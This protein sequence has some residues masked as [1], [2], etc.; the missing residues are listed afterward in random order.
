VLQGS[1]LRARLLLIGAMAIAFSFAGTANAYENGKLPEKA[2]APIAI[3]IACSHPEGQLANPAAAGFNTMA[4]GAGKR[5]EITGCDSAYRPYDRQVYYRQYWC[6]LG[7]CGNAA[8]PGTSNH[9]LG[10]AIDVPQWM[11][12]YIDSSGRSYGF[13]KSC[14][15]APQEWWHVLFCAPFNRPDPGI[16]LDAP[17]LQ[18]GSGGVGQGPWVKKAQELLR[19]HGFNHLTVD[20]DYGAHTHQAVAQFQRAEKIKATGR[21]GHT[22]WQHLRKPVVNPHHHPKPKPVPKPKPKPHHHGHHKPKPKPSG[23]VHGI[24]VSESQGSIDWKA[25]SSSGI[26]FAW[27]KATEGQDY[28]D[29]FFNQGRLNAVTAAHIV[30]GVYHFLRPI[31]GRAGAKEAT[32]FAAVAHNAG[33]GS[34]FLRPVADVETTSLSPAATCTYVRSFLQQTR[35]LFHAKPIV[36]TFPSFAQTELAGCTWLKRYPL[37][38]ANLGVSTP[39]V[40]A[41]WSGYLLWQYSW[42]GHVAGISG[43][44]D[45]DTLPGGLDQLAKLRVRPPKKLTKAPIAKT[46]APSLPLP[47]AALAKKVPTPPNVKAPDELPKPSDEVRQAIGLLLDAA[48]H[49]FVLPR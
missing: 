8:V 34:G 47:K 37:W 42:T 49:E 27:I 23:P 41:P 33:Y 2:L 40:P 12:G 44:V 17:R 36:Y 29:K 13:A 21:I 28:T 20:G 16:H 14:S 26:R 10:Y 46:P 3:A 31:P 48:A 7:Q 30:P 39:T 22:T 1:T 6:N 24:D 5:L 9:G 11:R 15:D 32:Y 4:L 35:K 19:A 45:L 18:N 25:V 38:I 43:N